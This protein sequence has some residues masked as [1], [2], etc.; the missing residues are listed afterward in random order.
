MP[1][2][3]ETLLIC[4]LGDPSVG[5]RDQPRILAMGRDGTTEDV[6][7]SMRARQLIRVLALPLDIPLAGLSQRGSSN[8]LA[9]MLA[10][11]LAHRRT[12]EIAESLDYSRSQ[13][14]RI[15]NLLKLELEERRLGGHLY[16]EERGWIGLRNATTDTA[17]LFAAVRD[18]QWQITTRLLCTV[19]EHDPNAALLLSSDGWSTEARAHIQDALRQAKRHLPPSLKQDNT[20]DRPDLEGFLQSDEEYAEGELVHET[21]VDLRP[22]HGASFPDTLSA[23]LP[24]PVTARPVTSWPRWRRRLRQTIP[25]AVALLAIG[26]IAIATAPRQAKPSPLEIPVS[27]AGAWPEGNAFAIANLTRA[28]DFG[29]PTLAEPGDVLLVGVRLDVTTPSL[30]RRQPFVLETSVN[31]QSTSQVGVGLSLNGPNVPVGSTGTSLPVQD[32]TSAQRL[33]LV[34]HSTE[35]LDENEQMI[36]HLPDI[37]PNTHY[38][39]PTLT[40]GKLYYV[41]WRLQSIT[42][43]RSIDGQLSETASVYCAHP[44]QRFPFNT[45]AKPSETLHCGLALTNWGPRTLRAVRV[46]IWWNK[47]TAGDQIHLLARASA[48]RAEPRIADFMPGYLNIAGR[49][50]SATL[51]YVPGSQRL[52]NHAGAAAGRVTGIALSE[53]A[54]ISALP[55]GQAG[56]LSLT[57]MV[58]VV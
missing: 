25:L 13:T 19:A 40:V 33:H 35:L 29:T 34:P 2:Q 44:R 37:R 18:E 53:E 54:T 57:F 45:V 38:S 46:R 39:L 47:P 16:A 26:V 12:S 49:S 5:S 50:R 55:P 56:S 9:E 23:E 10:G 3:D 6:R 1:N 4:F 48:A 27:R 52:V 30:E 7:L 21:P 17:M 15:R 22:T 14:W 32:V 24:L 51:E 58:R 28:I 41:E 42:T 20:S 11:P 36:M 43:P 31:P 8:R